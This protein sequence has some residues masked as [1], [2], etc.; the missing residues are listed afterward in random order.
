MKG[1]NFT[2]EQEEVLRQLSSFNDNED[3]KELR[4]TL[5]LYYANK[6][7]EQMAELEENGDWSDEL[8]KTIQ[9]THLRTPY[10]QS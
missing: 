5:C 3:V 6:V 10:T 4:R 8:Q 9:N 1:I 2:Q 7:E